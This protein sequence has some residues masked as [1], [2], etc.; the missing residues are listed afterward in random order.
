MVNCFKVLCS[1]TVKI[2]KRDQEIVVSQKLKLIKLVFNQWRYH[3]Q[4]SHEYSQFLNSKLNLL[5]KV[6]N[7]RILI[8]Y[9]KIMNQVNLIIILF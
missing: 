1:K 5:I 9:F 8:Y 3:F 4:Y 2:I 7:Y 6:K